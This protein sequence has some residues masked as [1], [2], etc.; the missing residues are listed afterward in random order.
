MNHRK[1]MLYLTVAMLLSTALAYA[2]ALHPGTDGLTL[3]R[4]QKSTGSRTIAVLG[5]LAPT[6][7]ASEKHL[8]EAIRQLNLLAPDAVFTVGNLVNPTARNPDDFTAIRK[9]LDRLKMPWYPCTGHHENP[10]QFEQLHKKHFGPLH[11]S[12][13]CGELRIIVLNSEETRGI[14][15]PDQLTWLKED[16]RRVFVHGQTTQVIVITHRPLWRDETSNWPDVHKLLVEFNRKPIVHVEGMDKSNTGGGKVVAVYAGSTQAY[17]DEG[18]IDG[19]RYTV[20]GATAARIRQDAATEIRGFALLK[21]DAAMHA[22]IIGMA[23][24]MGGGTIMAPDVITASERAILE[25]IQ[26][27]PNDILGVAGVLDPET[28]PDGELKLMLGNPLDVPIRV[29]VR[30]ASEQHLSTPTLRENANPA[31]ESF[32]APWK[33]ATPYLTRDL[34]AGAKEQHPLHITRSSTPHRDRL[35][36]LQLASQIP[37]QVEFVVQ[38]KDNRGRTHDI[39]LKRRIPVIPHATLLPNTT[40]KGDTFVWALHGDEPRKRSPTWELTWNGRHLY[41]RIHVDDATQTPQDAISIAWAATPE[42]SPQSVQ[43]VLLRP[44]GPK[45]HELWQNSGVGAEQTELL[46]SKENLDIKVLPHVGGYVATLMLPQR[47]LPQNGSCV[48]N[49]AV[50]DNDGSSRTWVRSWSKESLGPPGWGRVTLRTPETL[51]VPT[52]QP[53]T[54]QLPTTQP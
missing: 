14:V 17:A 23:G 3:P 37:P 1:T 13:Q 45:G 7:H 22:S 52:T 2:D 41:A 29:H 33:L 5:D 6:N 47:M 26:A 19:I 54:T 21:F 12:V 48:M 28:K 42:S 31:I 35:F 36:M 51:P 18:P 8:K 4:C 11:Y 10:Q 46:P 9:E 40:V 44:F 25:K 32:D 38:W 50:H 24:G 27:I 20:L 53:A 34:P 15:S 30:L 39:L 49:I 43:R 16:L